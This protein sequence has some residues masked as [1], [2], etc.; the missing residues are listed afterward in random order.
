LEGTREERC[1]EYFANK[2]WFGFFT[3]AAAGALG[4]AIIGVVQGPSPELT[5]W[6]GLAPASGV[7]AA[8]LWFFVQ[9]SIWIR[10][11]AVPGSIAVALYLFFNDGAEDALRVLAIV[12]PGMLVIGL[13]ESRI[14]T[15]RT[16]DWWRSLCFHPLG[17]D[18]HFGIKTFPNIEESA[19][20][21]TGEQR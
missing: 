21:E 10:Q 19:A 14:V 16:S 2:N 18:R 20:R 7:F 4:G 3:T 11:L 13:T 15:G 9:T 5:S 6:Y 12:L 1:R 17:W 8:V